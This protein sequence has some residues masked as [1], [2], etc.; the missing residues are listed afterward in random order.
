[1]KIEILGSCDDYSSIKSVFVSIKKVNFKIS[2]FKGDDSSDGW[3]EEIIFETLQERA[4]HTVEVLDS[5]VPTILKTLGIKGR[6]ANLILEEIPRFI[7]AMANDFL[8]KFFYRTS[9]CGWHL[10]EEEMKISFIRIYS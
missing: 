7:A 4:E 3:E 8:G 1:M 5:D 9:G 2:F 10:G 6:P